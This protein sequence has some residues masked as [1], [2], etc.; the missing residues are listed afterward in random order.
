MT[1]ANL[2]PV[3]LSVPVAPEYPV[4]PGNP[5]MTVEGL[6][7]LDEPPY[8]FNRVVSL[9][10]HAGRHWDAPSHFVRDPA[11]RGLPATEAVPLE[12]LIAPACV[13][14]ATD[15]AGAAGPGESPI[16]GRDRV[17]RWERERAVALV[18][19]EGAGGG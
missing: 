5:A 1:L 7:T 10:Q 4:W 12:R 14:D 19:R 2:V 11:A 16:L 17:L 15:L 3:D 6:R 9:D 8:C 13:L 18:P